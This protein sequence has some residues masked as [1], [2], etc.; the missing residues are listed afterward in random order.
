MM[1][2]ASN[3]VASSIA[4][5]IDAAPIS[6]GCILLKPSPSM[7][8]SLLLCMSP[9]VALSHRFELG[10]AR[11]LCPGISDVDFLSD[12]D[13]VVDLDAEIADGALDLGVA[14]QEL[15][16]SEVPG[17]SVDQRRLGPPERVRA[18]FQRIETD[19]GNP[20]ADEAGILS[21]RQSASRATASGE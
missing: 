17:S 21:S 4:L 13:R 9:E 11:Q 2:R 6:A 14:K 12:L 7:R 18:E 15:N 20:L 1:A 10:R 8:S 16:G 5:K 3:T 19:A